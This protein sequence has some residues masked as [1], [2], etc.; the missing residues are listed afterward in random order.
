[1]KRHLP[2]TL[3]TLRL[4]LGPVALLLA[5]VNAPRWIFLPLLVGGTLSDIFDGILARRFG[6]S[7]PALR[8]YD[9]IADVIYYLFILGALWRLCHE[10]VRQNLWAVAV[11]LASE[12]AGI[13]VCV[14]KFKKYPATHS[15][16][17]K[18]YGLCLLGAL[19]AL[20]AFEAGNWA[21]ITLAI[22]AAV[23][24]GE[25]ILLH[26]LAKTPPVDVTSIVHWWKR[27]QA[28]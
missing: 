12:A 10:V 16:L 19:I 18:F 7:T 8:R 26:L 28:I 22:V 20:L 24:N 21:V 3:T 5:F 27:R 6:V 1:M 13:L 23:A 15:W 2:F 4:L 25:I 14:V 9:S 17:A 11:I